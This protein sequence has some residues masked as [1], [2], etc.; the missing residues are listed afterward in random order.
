LESFN[1]QL[2]QAIGIALASLGEVNDRPRDHRCHRVGSINEAKRVQHVIKDMCKRGD[3]F[4]L[5]YARFEKSMDRHD[6]PK[7]PAKVMLLQW[8]LRG[9]GL[10]A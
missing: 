6:S 7:L 5:K 3:F 9:H 1:G 4:G 8:E 2:L 10:A